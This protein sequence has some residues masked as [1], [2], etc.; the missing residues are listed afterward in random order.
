MYIIFSVIS[1]F[2]I[3]F[4]LFSNV[5]IETFFQIIT[6]FNWFWFILLFVDLLFCMLL[7]GVRL[8]I[9]LKKFHDKVDYSKC[10]Y[11]IFGSYYINTVSPARLG[12]VY[13]AYVLNK[14]IEIKMGNS[15]GSIIIARISDLLVLIIFA[16]STIFY[17]LIYG[18]N[19]LKGLTPYAFTYLYPVFIMIIVIAT[20]FLLIM[21]FRDKF[22]NLLSKVLKRLPIVKEVERRETVENLTKESIDAVGSIIKSKKTFSLSFVLTLGI[23][24][25]DTMTIFFITRAINFPLGSW[26]FLANDLYHNMPMY[27][28]I[29]TGS[30]A[31]LS[32]SFVILPGGIGQY[33]L[34]GAIILENIAGL[35]VLPFGFTGFLVM[36]IEHL[37]CRATFFVVGGN[38]STYKLGKPKDI[39]KKPKEILEKPNV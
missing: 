7:R 5:P 9:L 35:A 37:L 23:I 25:L 38:I 10:V 3:I 18:N 8:Q 22:L 12:D 14:S 20:G 32:L 4:Y 34:V 6:N 1:I 19:L 16:I 15:I 2:V 28:T 30:M 24:F 17:H 13:N 33:E 26:K 31:L 29:M 36:F 21:I 39:I 11:S 27:L